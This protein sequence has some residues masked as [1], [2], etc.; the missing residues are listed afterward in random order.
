MKVGNSTEA[1][2]TCT[3]NTEGCKTLEDQSCGDYRYDGIGID[4]FMMEMTVAV[5]DGIVKAWLWK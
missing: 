2:L 5:Q 1:C 3:H 4:I